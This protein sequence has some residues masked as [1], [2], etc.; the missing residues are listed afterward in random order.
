MLVDPQAAKELTRLDDRSVDMKIDLEIDIQQDMVKLSNMD[1]K[2]LGA[3]IQGRVEANNISSKKPSAKGMLKAEGPDL[4]ALMQVIGQFETG[5]DAKL[6]S[7]GQR[8]SKVKDKSF[9]VG[10]EFDIN[11]EQGNILIP[12]FSVKTLGINAHGQLD[13]KQMNSSNPKV[14]GKFS[15]TGEKLGGLLTA[16]GNKELGD[17]LKNITVEAGVSSVG[18]GIAFSPL[19][20]KA[21]FAGKQIPKSPADV[22]LNVDSRIDLEKQTLA[23]K[24]MTLKGLGLDIAGNINASKIMTGKPIVNGNLDARGSDMALLFKLA[25]TETLARQLASLGDRSFSIKAKLDADI[26]KGKVKISDLSAQLVGASIKGHIETSNI[27]TNTPAVKGSLQASGPDLPTL[28]QIAGKLS[29]PDSG[30]KGIG[31]KL[32][33]VPNKSFDIATEFDVDFKKGDID[34]PILDIKTLG[35]TAKGQMKAK[36]MNTEN[37]NIDGKL[38]VK[39]E[40]LST[41]L[42]AFGQADLGEVMQSFSV[43]AGLKGNQKDIAL[44]PFDVKATFAGKQIPNPPVTIKLNAKTARASLEKQSFSVSQLA[45]TGL[46]MAMNAN[47]RASNIFDK[48]K[49]N[50]DL[51]IAEFNLREFAKQLNQELP[52]TADKK[53]F[54]KVGIKT[55]F[56]GSHDSISFNDLTM[57]LDNTQLNGNLAVN[58]F[59]QPDIQ[60]N[61]GIDSINADRYLPPASKTKKKDKKR[62]KKPGAAGKDGSS[63]SDLPVEMLRTL[64][65]KGD[66]FIGQLVLSNITMKKIK[67]GLRAKDGN[68]HLDPSTADLYQGKY[69]GVI[70]LDV[71]GKKPK[72]DI[73]TS[74]QGVQIEPLLKDYEQ[75]PESQLA[76]VANISAHLSASGKDPDKL[77][78]ALN[79]KVELRVNDGILRGIDVRKTLEAAE[80]LLESKRPGQVKQGGETRFQNLTATMDIKNGVVTNKDLLILAPGFRVN[81]EGMLANF[82]DNTIKYNL[83]IAV[84]E[85]SA[86]RGEERFNIG[87]YKVPIKCR[88]SLDAISTACQPDYAELAKI[89][90]QKSVMDKIG[91]SIGIKLPGSGSTSKETSQ[92]APTQDQQTTQSQETQQQQQK[93]QAPDPVKQIEDTID[94]FKGIF[95]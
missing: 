52:K 12:K 63:S 42:T 50:G 13:G 51:N 45:L 76:G 72:L 66:L 53:V 20:V 75:K 33:K 23:M 1:V 27:Q 15:L 22:T 60:F 43:D 18:G 35:L 92:P 59:T 69:Q 5:E 8:L 90:L 26:E 14:D 58:H 77:K 6:K 19:Q 57:R 89:A 61:I 73:N 7:L 31:Q 46:G 56:S 3:T 32:G 74:L 64:K 41:L 95:D 24:N 48:P 36:G 84:D 29:G 93:S 83:A 30:L 47:V 21:T 34:L 79:G 16:L 78:R 10:A 85:S 87:G 2:V 55:A 40:K 88:G 49:F 54:Q 39:G 82:H 44:N 4:P 65:I 67:I 70:G 17:V 80:V 37:G 62:A 11:L 91:D 68:I 81:G 38:S 86:T 25:G 9:D 94:L 71:R 28:I